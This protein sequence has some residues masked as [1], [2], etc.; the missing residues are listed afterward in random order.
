MLT[1]VIFSSTVPSLQAQASAA[2]AKIEPHLAAAIAPAGNS[3]ALFVLS[4]QADLSRA[5]RLT[6]K[7]EKGQY[8]YAKL[9][10]VA[11]RTQAPIRKRLD[12]LGIPY[13]SFFSVNMIKVNASRDQLCELAGRDE[14]ERVELNM[15]PRGTLATV[16]GPNTYNMLRTGITWNVARIK[17][18]Q[19]WSMGM[20]GHGIVAACADTGVM[21]N[22]PALQS[23]HR[24]WN[25]S[26]VNQ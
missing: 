15:P 14:V 11:G 9:K 25:G 13:E 12:E 3:E 17:A 24:G 26:S 8:V 16:S 2:L 7:L 10:E 19:V 21:W 6:T 5:D 20:K 18:P 22:H 4:G 23:H 1:V